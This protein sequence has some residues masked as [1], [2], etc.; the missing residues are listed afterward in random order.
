MSGNTGGG[1]GG[2]PK[3]GAKETFGAAKKA[4]N[5]SK[6]ND[7]QNS[8]QVDDNQEE[9]G[10]V[11]DT[12]KSSGKG[13]DGA[14][15]AKDTAKRGKKFFDELKGI[16]SLAPL[17]S[18]LST[19]GI[20]L[21]IIFLIIGFIGFFTTLPGLAMEKFKDTAKSFL[22]WLLGS[23]S[24]D[25]S[26]EQITDL[27]KY[28]EELGYS[29]EGCGFVPVDS[30]KRKGDKKNGEV[31]KIE[32]DVE[33]SNLY[34]Y[35][36]ANERT[37]T[38]NLEGK[39]AFGEFKRWGSRATLLL[40]GP[41]SVAGV[42]QIARDITNIYE[43]SDIT[44]LGMLV[45]DD[46]DM[47]DP[48]TKVEVDRESNKLLVKEGFFQVDQVNYDLNGWT[49]RY[50]KPIELSLALH[51][52]T[53]APDF[54]RNFCLNNDLQT[55]VHIATVERDY[56]INYYFETEDGTILDK[57]KVNEAYE[58]LKT[59][60]D[61]DSNYSGTDWRSAYDNGED[62]S[63]FT[64][65]GDI[66]FPYVPIQMLDD[67][68][69]ISFTYYS[70]W[71]H[72]DSTMQDTEWISIVNSDGNPVSLYDN[73]GKAK[74]IIFNVEGIT[75]DSSGKFSKTPVCVEGE[76]DNV[77]VYLADHGEDGYVSTTTIDEIIDEN[78]YVYFQEKE[79][80]DADFNI[81]SIGLSMNGLI[82]RI[83]NGTFNKNDP[84]YEELS[85][86]MMQVDKL[87]YDIKKYSNE[88][89]DA[90]E[91]LKKLCEN[92]IAKHHKNYG[93]WYKSD[94]GYYSEQFK[95]I[96]N[97]KMDANERIEKLENLRNEC[98]ADYETIKEAVMLIESDSNEIL[99]DCGGISVS[100]LRLLHDFFNGEAEEID[101]YEPYITKVTHHWY[102][103]VYFVDKDTGSADSADGVYDLHEDGSGATTTKKEEYN[104]EGLPA[105]DETLNKLNEEGTIYVEMKGN[106]IEQLG[107]PEFV[108]DETWHYMVKNWL[109]NGYYFIYDGTVETAREI[110]S[111]KEYLANFG[112]DPENPLLV[113]YD[114]TGLLT[115]KDNEP[116]DVPT[117]QE[118]ELKAKELN[119]ELANADYIQAQNGE[120]GQKY[121]VRLQKINFAKK[122]SL[123]AFSILEGVHT[124]DGER[125]YQ[126][127]KN[128]L[129]E[130]GYFE[131]EDFE[132]IETSVLDWIIPE[133]NPEEWPNKKYDKKDN[134]YGTYIRSKA[135]L[136]TE[137][138]TSTEEKADKEE[139]SNVSNL[140]ES[141]NNY[142]FIGDSI[143][144][145]YSGVN[146]TT[147]GR[148]NSSMPYISKKHNDSI[149]GS[150]YFEAEVSATISNW[151]DNYEQLIKNAYVNEDIKGIVI[152]LGANGLDIEEMK[153]LLNNLKKD[154][155]GVPI[156]VQQTL[157][158]SEKWNNWA[159]GND[160]ISHNKEID[161]FNEIIKQ[162]CN[163]NGINFVNT[164]SGLYDRDGQLVYTDD[165]V[166]LNKKGCEIIVQNI[167]SVIKGTSSS[168]D[169][170]LTGFESGLEV[171]TPGKGYITNATESSITIKFTEENTVKDMT[172]KIE[173]FKVDEDI[174]KG[175]RKTLEKGE[176]IGET[177][178]EDIKL[179]MRDSKKA[180][181]N[182]IEDYMQPAKKGSY[183]VKFSGEV[184]EEFLYYLGVN[185]EGMSIDTLD[186]FVGENIGDG[187]ITAG[188]GIT[189]YTEATFK[190]LG[191][192]NYYPMVE[193]GLYPKQ[194]IIDVMMADIQNRI[195]YIKGKVNKELTQKEMEALVIT[196]YQRGLGGTQEL[197]DAINS[198][199]PNLQSIWESYDPKWPGHA[200]RRKIEYQIYCGGDY[201]DC[202][203]GRGKLIFA[204]STPFSDALDGNDT[205]TFG[206]E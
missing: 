13:K 130:L 47:D 132:L 38:V 25:V 35:I 182:N 71:H 119:N 102:K 30:V 142:L 28:I 60:I 36:L 32:C 166:H 24:I 18:A 183:N 146:G 200:K 41:W 203:S 192:D 2:A 154:F 22:G 12:A 118:I 160:A 91:D 19:I 55:E 99:D 193:G 150:C 17:V 189:N 68:S 153:T 43:S 188:P 97:D 108:K 78:L 136:D 181:I 174:K 116:V 197:F 42:V 123:A 176:K 129:I 137:V 87:V 163:V 33:D 1:S 186:Y 46:I 195:N 152:M 9:A 134:E 21:L 135:S 107:Q 156:Y 205:V 45:L 92:F 139:V 117:V 58:T 100:T 103:D 206:G 173:G 145:G 89:E 95:S 167:K 128:F 204:T 164:S 26:D 82:A 56:D 90:P 125:V 106:F 57:E 171:I 94:G 40:P 84:V 143:T 10:S 111:A 158:F 201:M 76:L 72:R 65:N 8:G 147:P 62:V 120:K 37:Y 98:K 169:K 122:S 15:K 69:T 51:L 109:T 66:E 149:L 190:E 67:L 104:P 39:S 88:K 53:M 162:Y 11:Q 133:Y 172:M 159:T 7:N 202:Y 49:G 34:A 168:K 151:N 96:I 113:D 4:F 155:L 185:I 115:N 177:T 141:I 81:K 44:K 48:N 80:T 59:A 54:V 144:V 3:G 178:D 74:N 175:E 191:Y 198:N 31:E 179:L 165:G 196:S 138:T 112:Y 50:G 187:T 64:E 6:S 61:I 52:S 101:T 127:L 14:K 157:H 124:E 140:T 29:L 184:S 121:K 5:D 70:D 83:N 75:V 199:N 63:L 114:N 131:E 86:L 180:I 161:Q 27:A 85:F 73:N 194:V 77:N 110:E 20:A 126:D 93:K 23:E 79:G 170:T 16:Q 105:D 148:F